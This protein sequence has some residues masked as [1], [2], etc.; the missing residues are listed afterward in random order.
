MIVA[1]NRMPCTPC[2]YSMDCQE[3]T[4]TTSTSDLQ[5]QVESLRDKTG[6]VLAHLIPLQRVASD[7]NSI[8]GFRPVDKL[9]TELI[10]EG[11]PTKGFH[12]KGKSASWGA[13][14][15]FICVN[16]GFSKLENV[17]NELISKSNEQTQLCISEGHAIAV[18]LE[19]PQSRLQHL[20]KNDMIDHL[21]LE[22]ADGI[23]SFQARGPSGQKYEFEARRQPGDDNVYYRILYNGRPIEV[24][25]PFFDTRPFTVDYDLLLIGP[26][27][28]D[29]GPQDNLQVPDV[30]HQVFRERLD[31]YSK[32]PSHPELRRDYDD[33]TSFYRKSDREIGNTSERV[34]HMIPIINQAL[35]GD[36][37]KLIHHA[38]DT[39]NPVTDP[40]SNYPATFVLPIKLGRFNQICMIEN[41]DELSELVLH[42]KD[43]G[44]HVPL[45]PVW[46][47]EMTPSLNPRFED[48]RTALKSALQN[49]QYFS[50]ES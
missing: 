49:R 9:A 5:Q 7:F 36:G 50:G 42:A 40:L 45:H 29:L 14:A 20:L 33:P 28:S 16:Q 27:I 6:M 18:P 37:E 43:E 23:C 2:N 26:H 48:A 34:R 47:K 35:V 4:D 39:K 10:A 1:F 8:I 31:H 13:Q 11:Y 30:T 46:E 21:S 17:S 25:A 19:V 32:M 3:V 41:E 15:G 22:N 38:S 12:L 44:Y 24:L